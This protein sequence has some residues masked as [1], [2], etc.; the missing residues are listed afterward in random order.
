MPAHPKPNGKTLAPRRPM[1]Q[2]ELDRIQALSVAS[3]PPGSAAKRFCRDMDGVRRTQPA[4][5]ITDE[6][7]RMLACYAWRFRRQIPSGLV[8]LVNPWEARR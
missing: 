4:L 6:Q 3:M 8:P 5:G 2:L 7:A 1:T